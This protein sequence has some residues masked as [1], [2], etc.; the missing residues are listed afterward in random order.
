MI[1]KATAAD[2]VQ[3]VP[4]ENEAEDWFLLISANNL[5][6]IIEKNSVHVVEYDGY[7]S[8]AFGVGSLKLCAATIPW[9]WGVAD[10]G[11]K[12]VLKRF[13][14]EDKEEARRILARLAP[15]GYTSPEGADD[16][17]TT[18]LRYMG[19]RHLGWGLWQCPS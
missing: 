11:L 9:I 8:F 5:D 4:F 2:L 6:E 17:Y 12:R 3:I 13:I 18:F 19:F 16:R 1:R 15:G 7:I 14:R 10:I